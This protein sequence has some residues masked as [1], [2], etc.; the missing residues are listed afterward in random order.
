MTPAARREWRNPR[1]FLIVAGGLLLA[2]ALNG[3][4]RETAVG[5]VGIDE[6]L[7]GQVALDV[8]LKDEDGNDVTLR[9]LIDKPT[10][11]TLN[12][13]RC[14]GICTPLLYGVAGVLNQIPIEPGRDFQVITVSFDPQDTP[15]L[16]HEK[17]TSFLRQM[18]RPFQP[19][20]WRFLTGDARAT[21]KVAD[22]VGFNYRSDRDQFIHPGAIMVI[23]AHGIVSR[24]M[25]GITFVSADVEMAVQEAASGQV[26]PTIAKVLAFCYSYDPAGRGYVLN[27]TRAAGA[28]TLALAGL[29]AAY[30]LVWGRSRKKMR[31]PE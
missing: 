24:Y 28:A 11:L 19:A 1:F 14:A 25:Y 17:R 2:A 6:K 3:C 22:S 5:G 27:I 4:A 8:T 31:L 7:G 20:A 30:V 18:K 23:T 21:R 29:F 12:Y 13:L 10:I 26:R 15:E 16:A 9:R